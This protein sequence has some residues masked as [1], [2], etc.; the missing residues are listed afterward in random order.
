MFNKQSELDDLVN[1]IRKHIERAKLSPIVR[2]TRRG[3]VV[4][5]ASVALDPDFYRDGDIRYTLVV[6]GVSEKRVE[7]PH[8]KHIGGD[9][10]PWIIC[11]IH[12]GLQNMGYRISR[13]YPPTAIY[14]KR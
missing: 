3:N 9:L 8:P 10:M 7:G 11:N 5:S 12:E 1:M 4:I 2:R 6:K 14:I 13:D